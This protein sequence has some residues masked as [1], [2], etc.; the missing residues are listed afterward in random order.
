MRILLWSAIGVA[1]AELLCSAQT[2]VDKPSIEVAAI[3][4]NTNRAAPVSLSVSGPRLII[5]AYGLP[6]LLMTAY[7]MDRFQIVGGP[8]WIDSDRFDITVK[9]AGQETLTS[10]QVR[11]LIQTLLVQRFQLRAHRETQDVPAYD[12]VIAKSGLRIKP[13]TSTLPTSMRLGNRGTLAELVVLQGTLDQFA[14][15]LSGAGIGRPVVNRTELSGGYDFTLKWAP[16]GAGNTDGGVSIF[17]A[18]QEQLGLKLES[19]KAPAVV[20]VIDSA[21]KPSGN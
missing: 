1:A 3:R 2:P 12:L 9:A 10:A 21:E 5:T 13:S 19:G 15:Y 6:G 4:Q 14:K 11:L 16:D 18:I 17:T 20:M 8:N 7:G